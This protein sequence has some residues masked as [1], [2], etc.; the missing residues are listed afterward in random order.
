[1][2]NLNL[3]HQSPR[4][5]NTDP[6][7]GVIGAGFIVRDIQLVAYSHAGY[8]VEAIASSDP[9]EARAVAKLRSV[10]KAWEHW[11]ELLADPRVEILDIAVPPSAQPEII[12]E[13]IR[14]AGRIKG[15]LAQKPL[16][17]DYATARNVVAVCAE[18]GI[19]L[20]VNQNMRYDQSIRAL[21]TILCRRYLGD[22]VLATIEMRAIPHWQSWLRNYDRLT[23]LNMSIHHL[24]TFR[25]LFG[26]PESVYC[27]ARTDPRTGFPHRDGIV[28]Y[29]LEYANGFR[30]TAWDDVWAGPARE[31][32]AADNYI[33]WRVE[34]T[35]GTAQGTIGWPE[36]PNAAPSTIDFTTKLEPGCWF[37]PR[38]SEVWFPDA[39]EGTMGQLLEAVASGTEP[40]VN[41]R[42]NLHTV[43]LVDACYRS[44]EEHRPVRLAEIL[45]A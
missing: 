23:L 37:R 35:D 1:M 9:D 31:G 27:S 5:R 34:G 19:P 45:E 17:L 24:D 32:A 16:A 12:G 13:A 7:I 33:K 11:R 3:D 15:I 30:A 4:S 44:I 43:A 40:A 42:E 39:F 41:G 6:G 25:F 21:K 20:A 29:I 36:Y 28:L 10:P 38:W 22:P 2:V 8:R 14:Y 18:A 26:D